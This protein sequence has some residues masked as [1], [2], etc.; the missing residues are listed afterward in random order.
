MWL[1]ATV[2]L[3]AVFLIVSG[4]QQQDDWTMWV[5]LC[6]FKTIDL[7]INPVTVHAVGAVPRLFRLLQSLVPKLSP[8]SWDAKK[9]KS[10]HW[11]RTASRWVTVVIHWAGIS[12]VWRES[13]SSSTKTRP[14]LSQHRQTQVLFSQGPGQEWVRGLCSQGWKV[15][16]GQAVRD[17]RD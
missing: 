17:S 6:L 12:G 14:C 3:T 10:N 11:Q 1:R 16:S 2:F 7:T 4:K 13:S 8:M 9:K 5:F 15:R